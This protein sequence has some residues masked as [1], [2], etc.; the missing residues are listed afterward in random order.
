MKP[1]IV[2]TVPSL[3]ITVALV[4]VVVIFALLVLGPVETVELLRDAL[5]LRAKRAT[6]G[7]EASN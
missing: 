6:N 4:P 5:G 1:S 2:A 3:L 7:R